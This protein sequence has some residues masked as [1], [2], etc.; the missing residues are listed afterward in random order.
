[1]QVILTA[2]LTLFGGCVLFLFSQLI[3]EGIIKPYIE[4]RKILADI[5]YTLVYH[6]NV[7]VSAPAK[8]K[9]YE[10]ARI[11]EKLRELS[12]QLRSAITALPFQELLRRLQL[13]PSQ[14]CVRDAASR[15]IRISSRLIQAQAAGKKHDEIQQDM[16][17]IGDLLQIDVAHS[18]TESNQSMRD[19]IPIQAKGHQ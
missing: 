18:R 9:P 14:K 15:L 13:I 17:A 6:A 1:M 19:E 5:T 12:A 10:H 7:I 4:Y 2:L 8:S 16:T 3:T 11:A